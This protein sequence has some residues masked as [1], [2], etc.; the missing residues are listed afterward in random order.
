MLAPLKLPATI[1]VSGPSEQK[2]RM[3]GWWRLLLVFSCI[4][5]ILYIISQDFT[6]VTEEKRIVR[7]NPSHRMITV[8]MNTFKRHDMMT[9]RLNGFI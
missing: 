8:V 4:G 7:G 2:P 3:Q 1:A 9:G 5:L 6:F